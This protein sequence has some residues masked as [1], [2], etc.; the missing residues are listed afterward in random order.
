MDVNSDNA[1]FNIATVNEGNVNSNNNN[2]CNSDAEGGNDNDNSETVP[3]RP[4]ASANCGY[5]STTYIRDNVETIY[6]L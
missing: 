3:V 1:N 4:I 6:V 5:I 2:L